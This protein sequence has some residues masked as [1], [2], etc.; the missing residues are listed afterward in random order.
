MLTPILKE[1]ETNREAKLDFAGDA[2]VASLIVGAINTPIISTLFLDQYSS[3][4]HAIGNTVWHMGEI[5]LYG[6]IGFLVGGLAL[7]ILIYFLFYSKLDANEKTARTMAGGSLIIVLV[8][9][10]H[11]YL[12]P[13]FLPNDYQSFALYTFP[14]LFAYNAYTWY[15]N[16]W[17]ASS[18]YFKGIED[19]KRVMKK[20]FY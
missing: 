4:P 3:V 16:I 10:A 15:W 20:L 9:L 12:L 7:R 14:I 11:F 8:M 13:A 18:L 1:K 2:A 6:S 19:K 5:F 17:G